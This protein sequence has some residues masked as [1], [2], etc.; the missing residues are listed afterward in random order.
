MNVEMM[1]Y[2]S[3]GV[4]TVA[5]SVAVLHAVRDL[6]I[7]AELRRPQRRDGNTPGR[8]AAYAGGGGLAGG[9]PAA[10]KPA[11][12]PGDAG[13]AHPPEG[14]KSYDPRPQEDRARRRI[15]YH[16]IAILAVVIVSLLAM[17]AFGLIAVEDVERFGVIVGPI[18]TL[19]T[20]ATSFYF[21]NRRG[22]K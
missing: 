11:D 8:A 19:V 17:V 9:G 7:R 6:M 3:V 14:G 22:G 12:G 5:L 16:L 2:L 4:A 15:A 20:A 10:A 21:G 1:L 18:V 13:A